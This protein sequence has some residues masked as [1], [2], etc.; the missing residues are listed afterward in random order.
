[1]LASIERRAPMI[2]D[3]VLGWGRHLAPKSHGELVNV[4]VPRFCCG[5]ALSQVMAPLFI[6]LD[7]VFVCLATDTRKRLEIVDGVGVAGMSLY[8]VLEALPVCRCQVNGRSR[9]YLLRAQNPASLPW[10]Q[11]SP[12][13]SKATSISPKNWGG[14][15]L[16]NNPCRDVI[17][18][19][20]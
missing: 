16:F 3:D 9:V 15:L 7:L 5:R 13:T 19:R 17:G 20:V 11:S 4:V 18:N 1:M 12:E 6:L 10:T 8:L 2:K 14:R